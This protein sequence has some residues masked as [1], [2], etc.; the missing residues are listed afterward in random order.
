MHQHRAPFAFFDA[1]QLKKNF[2]FESQHAFPNPV[3]F[4][5]RCSKMDALIAWVLDI[6]QGV[7]TGS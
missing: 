4:E 5:G 2:L 7:D 3:R 6:I 1:S